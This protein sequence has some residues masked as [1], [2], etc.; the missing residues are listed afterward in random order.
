MP[1]YFSGLGPGPGPA[2]GGPPDGL[3]DNRVSFAPAGGLS[4]VPFISRSP[5]FIAHASPGCLPLHASNDSGGGPPGRGCPGGGLSPEPG[6]IVLP[7]CCGGLEQAKDTYRSPARQNDLRTT[8]ALSI[9]VT[10]DEYWVV[11][12]SFPGCV[13]MAPLGAVGVGIAIVRTATLA[14]MLVR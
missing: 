11:G 7:S 2:G 12:D 10:F 1:G 6:G 14:Q 9:L 13:A 4:Q 8:V 3:H 5:C